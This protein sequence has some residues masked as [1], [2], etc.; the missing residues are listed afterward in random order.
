MNDDFR[1]L[2]YN[3]DDISLEINST[4]DRIL[5][6]TLID[7]GNPFFNGRMDMQDVFSMFTT[8]NT[9]RWI[10]DDPYYPILPYSTMLMP[11]QKRYFQG[12]LI[13]D[14][15]TIDLM[16]IDYP[17]YLTTIHQI[18]Y[19]RI[20]LSDIIESAVC[21]VMEKMNSIQNLIE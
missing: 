2:Y 8:L 7:K 18:S 15:Y 11:I 16:T 20:Y 1:C 14:K 9:L 6:F 17:N 13:I 4:I 12:K 10:E 3:I 19:N 21:K 5:D